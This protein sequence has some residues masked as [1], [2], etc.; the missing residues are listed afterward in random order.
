MIQAAVV[1]AVYVMNTKMYVGNLAFEATELDVRELFSEH[2]AVNEVAIVMDRETQRPR[3]FAF[4]TM[5]TREGM[6][7]A[8]READGKNWNGRVL[9]VN[10]ARPREE[11]P[12]YSG[13]GGG[14]GGGGYRSGGGNGGG[15]SKRW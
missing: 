1:R 11:R 7:A 6:E 3:G 15:K 10:E 5:N 9:T 13:G 12:A 8:I 4:V 14:G 2:G